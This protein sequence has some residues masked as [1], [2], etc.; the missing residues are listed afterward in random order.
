MGNVEQGGCCGGG[1][2]MPVS[3]GCGGRCWKG[4]L[5]R[6]FFI[7]ALTGSML[8]LAMF[9]S[10]VKE[11]QFIGRDMPGE[12]TTIAVDGEGEAFAKPDIAT[13]TFS[14]TEEKKTAA[15]ARKV[16]D[17]KVAAILAY[18]KEQGIDVGDNEGKDIKTTSYSL[19]PKHEWQE[20]KVMCISYPCP[21]PPGKQVLIGYEVSQSIDVKVRDLDKVGAVVGGLADKGATN[22]YGPNFM[23]EDEGG[24]KAAARNEAIKKAKAKAEALADE[25]GVKLVRIVS[26]NEGGVYP[27]YNYGK[28]GDMRAMSVMEEGALMPA[29]IPVGENKFVS[30]VTIV[31]EIE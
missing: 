11:F 20:T 4:K 28:G 13:I 22:M 23:V 26:F 17:D 7:L 25:L 12:Q 8:L 9:F 3:G 27:Y 5:S 16:V 30:N 2:A 19:Y 31:Y 1:G 21:Q 6:G 24:V 15:E 29:E 18:L 10:E 14:V